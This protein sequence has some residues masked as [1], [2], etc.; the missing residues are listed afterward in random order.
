MAPARVV[1]AGRVLD[2]VFAD[3]VES[4]GVT[5]SGLCDLDQA[6]ISVAATLSCDAIKTTVLHECI[7]G[8][9]DVLGYGWNERRVEQAETLFFLLMRS[10]PD[11]VEWLMRGG[12]DD[13]GTPTHGRTDP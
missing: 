4:E 5:L 9:A 2:L 10:N 6:R 11:L 8:V 13:V 12:K 3:R 7:H 1:I